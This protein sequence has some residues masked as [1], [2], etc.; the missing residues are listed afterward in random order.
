MGTTNKEHRPLTSGLLI[1]T[2]RRVGGSLQLPPGY[3]TLTGVARKPDGTKVLV[4]NLHVVTGSEF[5]GVSGDEEMFQEDVPIGVFGKP[6]VSHT[7]SVSKRVG[8]SPNGRAQTV[9]RVATADAAMF[10]L[11][12][13]VQAKFELH[14]NSGNRIRHIL[15]AVVEPVEN[16]DDEDPMQLTML[17]ARNGEGVVTVLRINQNVS[18]EGRVYTGMTVVDS[19]QRTNAPGDS[20]APY[21]FQEGPN[22]YR[23]SCIHSFG[24]GNRG[25]AFPASV[26][27]RVLGVKFGHPP[28]TAVAGAVEEV[29]PR[30]T[31]TLSAAGSSSNIEG[32]T[33]LTYLWELLE[34]PVQPSGVTITDSSQATA[35][36][37]APDNAANLV[38]RLTVT[39]VVGGKATA[40]VT[41]NVINR[42]PR[43]RPGY[44]QAVPVRTPVTLVGAARDRDEGHVSGMTYAWE[45]VS[46]PAG[47]TGGRGTRSTAS[48]SSPGSRVPLTTPTEKR[49]AGAEQAYLH[50]HCHWRLR[51]QAHRDG[52]R[53]T[54]PLGQRDHTLLFRHPPPPGGMTRAK[55][56]LWMV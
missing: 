44:N 34:D 48:G 36:F 45:V 22:R 1:T 42:P 5:I 29:R 26:A 30:E 3:G 15:D 14:D 37:T 40:T 2:A 27:E 47:A 6:P 54:L 8:A 28:P 31:V 39:D 49:P 19:S 11:E 33:T 52:P 20:G 35:T 53:R 4:T 55:R 16:E 21:L 25:W 23:M 56:G 10:E 51:L 9:A 50:P 13:G 24:S 7:P 46:A 32:D 41:I 38:F 17:G 18:M 12:S 43:A